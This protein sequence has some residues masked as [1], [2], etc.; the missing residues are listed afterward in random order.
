MFLVTL[1]S[2]CFSPVVCSLWSFALVRSVPLFTR[3]PPAAFCSS[4]R[5]DPDLSSGLC[6]LPYSFIRASLCCSIR[7]FSVVRFG[8]FPVPLL[9]SFSPAA[10]CSSLLHDPDL[11]SGVCPFPFSVLL[12]HGPSLCSVLCAS[13][14]TFSTFSFLF[15]C[16]PCL[17]Q[18]LVSVL[19]LTLLPLFLHVALFPIVLPV[20]LFL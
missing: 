2:I 20:T 12:L 17:T 6:G 11:R 18:A 9:T 1:F 7:L 14:Y 3:S 8:L 13:P 16:P 10:F 4:L 5:H 19:L 15:L